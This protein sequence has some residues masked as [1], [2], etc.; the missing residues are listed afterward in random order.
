MFHTLLFSES[1]DA[2]GAYVNVAAATDQCIKTSGDDVTVPVLNKIIGMAGLVGTAGAQARLTSP[3][4]RRVN[5]LY[6][7][8]TQEALVPANPAP[9]WLFPLAPIPIMT[10]ES[11]N[12]Q[13]NSDPAAAEQ[14]SIIVQLSD[15]PQ[16][17]IA[18]EI[19]TIMAQSTVTLVA[20][21]WAFAELT[22]TDDLPVGDYDVVGARVVAAN[23]TAFR[24]V[25]VGSAFRPGGL[26]VGDEDNIEDPSQRHGAMGV[27]FTFNTTQP[28]GIEIAASAATASATYSVYIDILSKA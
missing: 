26:C 1:Q 13:L 11:L 27:W 17:S 23:G 16:A 15:G 25:P 6:I 9:R 21:S 4:L 7:T 2:S 19:R 5:P 10:N 12:A 14:E 3:S 8:P 24:F 20:G 22:F 28:P 18:G